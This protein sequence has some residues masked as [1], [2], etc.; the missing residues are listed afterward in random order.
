MARTP[1]LV[2]CAWCLALVL[3]AISGC[4]NKFTAYNARSHI[5]PSLGTLSLTPEQMKNRYAR[6]HDVNSRQLSD[7]LDA[8]LLINRPTM[9]NRNPMP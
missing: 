7:D 4:S 5:N 6:T 3:V 1:Q 9:L 8:L 2:L